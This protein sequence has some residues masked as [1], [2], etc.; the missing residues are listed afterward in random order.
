VRRDIEYFQDL[1]QKSDTE[2]ASYGFLA[3][4]LTQE[5]NG[6]VFRYRD[7]NRQVRTSPSPVYFDDQVRLDDALLA[8]PLPFTPRE[9]QQSAEYS[10]ALR[11]F[12]EIVENDDARTQC[13][14]AREL[15]KLN[16]FFTS[17]ERLIDEKLSR[18]LAIHR[19]RL[20]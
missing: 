18:E 7:S 14:R 11:D 9:Q 2:A 19:T 17:I 12:T 15:G 4:E 1:A 3:N 5:C 13:L 16:D 10:A 20:S 8:L 6:V